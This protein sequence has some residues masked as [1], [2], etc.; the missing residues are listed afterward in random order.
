MHR[1]PWLG[2]IFALESPLE[3]FFGSK[4]SRL[5]FAGRVRVGLGCRMKFGQGFPWEESF[6]LAYP[7]LEAF[8]FLVVSL[9]GSFGPGKIGLG[10]VG[11][12]GGGEGLETKFGQG[13]PCMEA[14]FVWSLVL[15]DFFVKE[16]S[17]MGGS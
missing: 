17:A 12:F 11:V 2:V 9:G 10:G 8:P 7:C 6:V 14:F 1:F 13:L 15:E 3:S 5:G 4:A 16:V